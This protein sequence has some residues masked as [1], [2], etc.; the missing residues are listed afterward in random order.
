MA[1]VAI[2][3]VIYESVAFRR[4]EPADRPENHAVA[5]QTNV[6]SGNRGMNMGAICEVFHQEYN[7][8]HIGAAARMCEL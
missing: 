7:F 5:F 2:V 6:Q 3:R 8:G 4:P 1:V